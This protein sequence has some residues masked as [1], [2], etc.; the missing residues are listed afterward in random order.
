MNF[1]WLGAE[2][3]ERWRWH[4]HTPGPRWVITAVFAGIWVAGLRPSV[5]A[6]PVFFLPPFLMVG[7]VRA[8]DRPPPRERGGPGIHEGATQPPAG[9]IV[10][11]GCGDRH[12][13]SWS[14]V[15]G[16]LIFLARFGDPLAV[17]D[18]RAGWFVAASAVIGLLCLSL[19]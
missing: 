8:M 7:A 18:Q 11:S 19:G 17:E 12:A 15:R 1:G 9:A 14:N 6:A 2:F 10:R 4:D 13:G 3:L 16:L 5:V